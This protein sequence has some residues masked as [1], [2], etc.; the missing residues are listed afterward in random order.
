[1]LNKVINIGAY[2]FKYFPLMLMLLIGCDNPMTNNSSCGD[3][4]PDLY[5]ELPLV[6]GVYQLEYNQ[7]Y[8]Q[9]FAPI[10]LNVGSEGTKKVAFA[11]DIIVQV[12]GQWFDLVNTSSYT[13]DDG[14]TQ[15]TLGVFEQNVGEIIN[16]YCGFYD[17]CDVHY[18][19]QLQVEVIDNE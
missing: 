10:Y 15:T 9:T 11:S 12:Q 18:T 3:S 19:A 16:I 1:M 2:L 14:T 13:R 5:C 17:D 4:N 7:N 6:D 8:T